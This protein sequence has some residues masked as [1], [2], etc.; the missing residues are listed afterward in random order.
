MKTFLSL[1]TQI[2]NCM[3]LFLQKPSDAKTHV[4]FHKLTVQT[5]V[6]G[7]PR[8]RTAQDSKHTVQKPAPKSKEPVSL[9]LDFN[10]GLN[11]NSLPEFSRTTK[12]KLY[13]SSSA[14]KGDRSIAPMSVPA[15]TPMGLHICNG[16]GVEHT[17]SHTE[18][19][20]RLFLS[21][22]TTSSTGPHSPL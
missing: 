22:S 16:S 1:Q 20:T 6:Q 10:S 17:H 9:S 7:P 13:S 18:D 19:D 5:R 4:P 15:T 2:R 8:L 14:V 3:W 21:L 11:L 12:D